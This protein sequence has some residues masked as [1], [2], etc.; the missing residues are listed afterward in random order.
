MR[1]RFPQADRR[2]ARA[3]GVSLRDPYQTLQGSISLPA[4]R[5]GARSGTGAGRDGSGGGRRPGGR[6]AAAQVADHQPAQ[7]VGQDHITRAATPAPEPVI[8]GATENRAMAGPAPLPAATAKAS[9]APRRRSTPSL[10][11]QTAT[12]SAAAP[13][14]RIPAAPIWGK[15]GDLRVSGNAAAPHVLIDTCR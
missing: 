10:E 3:R 13:F 11:Q 6:S 8:W 5:A 4:R 12:A 7:H 14:G 1:R 9:R 2:S 15:D